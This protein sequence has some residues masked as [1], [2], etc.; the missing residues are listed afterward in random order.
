[1]GRRKLALSS[2][3]FVLAASLI[4]SFSIAPPVTQAADHRDSTIVDARPEGDFPTFSHTSARKTR[5]SSC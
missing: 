2:L 5:P 1:M 4:S 3:A